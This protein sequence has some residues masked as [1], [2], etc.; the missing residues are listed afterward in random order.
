MAALILRPEEQ[1][2]DAHLVFSLKEAA[3]KAWSAMGGRFLDHQEVVV[4]VRGSRFGRARRRRRRGP[5]GPVRCRRRPDRRARGRGQRDLTKWAMGL[6]PAVVGVVSVEVGSDNR[7]L[8]RRLAPALWRAPTRA[9]ATPTGRVGVVVFHQPSA[10]FDP[11]PERG[12]RQAHRD[13]PDADHGEDGGADVGRRPAVGDQRPQT[14]EQVGHRVVRS[15]TV[16]SQPR[17]CLLRAGTTW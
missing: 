3:Y 16:A 8:L 1:S 12:Q 13:H 4:S 9:R 10:A 11:A 14:L 17:E 7:M 5:R 6:M 15:A 2:L